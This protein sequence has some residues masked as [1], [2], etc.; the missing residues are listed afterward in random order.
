MIL[1]KPRP[2]ADIT[3]T[4][5]DIAGLRLLVWETFG[6]KGG[7]GNLWLPIVC[8]A[9]GS[10]FAEVIAQNP[11]GQYFQPFDFSDRQRQPL[12]RF[13]FQ[14]LEQLQAPPAVYLLQFSLPDPPE[15]LFDRLIPFPDRPAS[16]SIGVQ[17]PDLFECHWRCITHQP[18]RDLIIRTFPKS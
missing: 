12:Y 3:H 8:T 18:I 14:L 2:M 4:C 13:G 15:F 10:L 5:A 9:R 17:E 6:I 16:A 11:D 7:G 1:K